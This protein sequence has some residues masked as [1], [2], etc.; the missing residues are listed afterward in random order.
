MLGNKKT[1][2]EQQEFQ[3]SMSAVELLRLFMDTGVNEKIE[4]ED[5]K[6]KKGPQVVS[7][8]LDEET[9]EYISK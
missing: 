8:E 1:N 7:S 6:T 5:G 3:N 9:G 4:D 2:H